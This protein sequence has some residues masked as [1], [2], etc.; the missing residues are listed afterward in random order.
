MNV[1]FSQLGWDGTAYMKFM[2]DALSSLPVIN[3]SGFYLVD[4]EV[5][6]SISGSLLDQ[7]QT[8]DAVQYYMRRNFKFSEAES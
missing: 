8:I 1:L 3:T 6:D 5:T 7:K 2:N 4:G